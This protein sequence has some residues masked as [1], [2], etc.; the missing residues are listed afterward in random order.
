MVVKKKAHEKLDDK[1]IQRVIDALNG[2]KPITKKEACGMLHINYNTPR[3]SKIIKNYKEEKAYRQNRMDKNRG[4]SVTDDEKKE[5]ISQ[6]L[7]GM[8]VT[9]IAKVMYRSTPFVKSFIDKTGVPTRVALGEE[10]I[11]PD[12]CVKEEF[13]IGEWVWFNDYH[14][15]A[16]GGKAGKIVKDLT[17]TSEASKENECNCYAI[18]YWTGIVWQDDFWAPWWPG[19]KRWKSHTAKLAYEIGSIQHLI[20]DYGLNEESL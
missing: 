19:V 14:P 18:H 15:N 5:I 3:L 16:R 17:S 4:K 20:D 13:E 10:F 1:N 2:E 7:I 11:V 9:D 12:E 6:Y 8:T